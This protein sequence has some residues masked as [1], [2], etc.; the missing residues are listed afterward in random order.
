MLV[1]RK[2]LGS[3][4]NNAGKGQQ[5]QQQQ[6]QQQ[7]NSTIFPAITPMQR[8]GSIPSAKNKGLEDKMKS[9]YQQKKQ[10]QQP[11]LQQ[12]EV[13][14][15]QMQQQYLE[16]TTMAIESQ[17]KPA[18]TY[19]SKIKMDDTDIR[20]ESSVMDENRNVFKT[21]LPQKKPKSMARAKLWSPEVENS[22][23]YQLGGWRDIEEYISS[24]GEPECWLEGLV[25]CLQNKKSGY[26]MYFRQTRECE[27]KHLNKVKVYTY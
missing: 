17:P 25:R 9:S 13:R 14:A 1:V 23:R 21:S 27:D 22:Y 24:Y 15:L 5:G 26:F 4:G 12:Q 11:Q 10:V 7:G 20:E 3:R 18:T 6:Q 2:E 16:P 8:K 19:Q